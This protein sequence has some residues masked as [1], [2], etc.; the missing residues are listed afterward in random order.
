LESFAQRPGWDKLDAVR[1]NK[2]YSL[3]HVLSRDIWDFVGNQYF[4]KCFYPDEFED[5]DP[6]ENLKEFYREFMPVEYSGV[7]MIDLKE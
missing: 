7:W 6:E 3:H 4:A 1:N 2:V 5:L